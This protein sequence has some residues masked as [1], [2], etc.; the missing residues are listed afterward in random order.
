MGK[1]TLSMKVK[2]KDAMAMVDMCTQGQR[3]DMNNMVL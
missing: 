2:K 3:E 1:E